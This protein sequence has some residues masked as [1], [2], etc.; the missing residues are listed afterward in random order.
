MIVILQRWNARSYRHHGNKKYRRFAICNNSQFSCTKDPDEDSSG[1][2]RHLSSFII[3]FFNLC[4]IINRIKSLGIV[5]HS[6]SRNSS[7]FRRHGGMME[8]TE[9]KY[10]LYLK[11]VVDP[12]RVGSAS[13]CRI[14]ISINSM[15]ANEKNDFFP[16]N[17]NM[18]SKMLKTYDTLDTDE[19]NK[20]LKS[21]NAET[22]SK[23]KL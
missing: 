19:K 13:V 10:L 4:T 6:V 21:G 12:D 17:F 14:Q 9:L 5:R 23:K 20:T 15:K 3:M 1:F 7:T 2:E 18:M 16:E 8:H 22:I 11:T